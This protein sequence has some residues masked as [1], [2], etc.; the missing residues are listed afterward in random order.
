MI[1]AQGEVDDV[2]EVDR[3]PETHELPVVEP[4]Q[5]GAGGN[6]FHREDAFMRQRRAIDEGIQSAP[7][8]PAWH[9]GE[10]GTTHASRHYAGDRCQECWSVSAS[11]A[12]GS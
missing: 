9:G 10:F 11:S 12:S 6:M 5:D 2:V 1:V 4:D 7:L 3:A 8:S